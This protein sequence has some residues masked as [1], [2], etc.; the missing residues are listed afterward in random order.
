MMVGVY[1]S[2]LLH[3]AQLINGP[4]PTRK[5]IR[6]P[7]AHFLPEGMMCG[8]LLSTSLLLVGAAAAAAAQ[9]LPRFSLGPVARMERVWLD[10]DTEGATPVAGLAAGVRV[11]RAIA[12]E[13]ELTGAAQ[14]IA[15]SYEGWFISYAQG[16]NASRAEIERLAPTARRRLDY[17]PGAGVAAMIVARAA[18]SARVRI[19]GRLGVSARRYTERSS[20]VVLTIPEGVDPARV[21]RDFQSQAVRT[22]RGGLLLGVDV[23]V[24]LTR[25]FTLA[26]QMRIVYSGPAGFGSEHR[27][28][29][30]GLS[31]RWG[32]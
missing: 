20:Y 17:E 21:A 13:G 27:E 10:G 28:L 15:R 32:F 3:R 11:S 6:R 19:A 25:R 9:S 12:V 14:D 16:P 18:T 2:V 29:G 1:G 8:T 26:P 31:G 5:L 7:R 22:V 4:L 24:A 30:L 23:D